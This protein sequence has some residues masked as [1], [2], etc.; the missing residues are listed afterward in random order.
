MVRSASFVVAA[1]LLSCA[2]VTRGSGLAAV[3]FQPPTGNAIFGKRLAHDICA[4]CHAV[5]G[6]SAP[7]PNSAATPFSDL[8][9]SPN[10]N[11]KAIRDWLQ[12]SHRTMPKIFLGDGE[13]DDVV[14]Y[15][16]SLNPQHKA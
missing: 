7:S 3:R 1:I 2:L 13:K 16:L 12:S 9:S 10:L 8:A 15:I 6:D 11:A 14:A 4:H 5:G